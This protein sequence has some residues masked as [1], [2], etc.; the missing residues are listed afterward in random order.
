[1]ANVPAIIF[2]ILALLLLIALIAFGLYY[3][4]YCYKNMSP[5]YTLSPT[6][7]V[8]D[9][10]SNPLACS[11]N[12]SPATNYC[13]VPANDAPSVCSSLSA[14]TG[15]LVADGAWIGQSG[16]AYAQLLQVQPVAYTNNGQS[17]AIYFSK[18]S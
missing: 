15:Y 5:D 9:P 4:T 6:S 13:I 12:V 10:N 16:T 18:N 17:G 3:Y 2:G 11:Q 1:M 8:W 14:C 7:N